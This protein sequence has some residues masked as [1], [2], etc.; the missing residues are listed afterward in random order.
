MTISL[1]KKY[2]TR[3]GDE[4]KLFVLDGGGHYPVIGILS[5]Q[6][7]W[8]AMR[9]DVNGKI[10]ATSL[11]S[12]DLVEVKPIVKRWVVIARPDTST[13][14][15]SVYVYRQNADRDIAYWVSHNISFVGPIEISGEVNE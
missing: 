3:Q 10:N 12:F 6:D 11:T 15:S 13:E 9:W 8:T 2:K 14:A 1:D 4:V 7:Y 5:S